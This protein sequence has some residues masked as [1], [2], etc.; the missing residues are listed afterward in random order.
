VTKSHHLLDYDYDNANRFAV[1]SLTTTDFRPQRF[2][3]TGGDELLA[4]HR[5]LIWFLSNLHRRIFRP[6]D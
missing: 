2:M 4:Y 1:A 6:V 3:I 5:N